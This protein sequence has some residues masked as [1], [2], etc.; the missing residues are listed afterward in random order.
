MRFSKLARRATVVMIGIGGAA[1]LG[2]APAL[3]EV[4]PGCTAADMA[5]VTTGVAAGLGAYLATHPD[6][7]AF[8]TGLQGYNEGPQMREDAIAATRTYLQ[9]NPQVAAELGAIRAPAVDF[10]NRCGIP[11]EALIEG[12]L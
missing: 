8:F 10:R 2:A 1:V 7:N 12:V 5:G 6:V 4:R 3:G 9:A 11:P